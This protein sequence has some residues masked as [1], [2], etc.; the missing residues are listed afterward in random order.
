MFSDEPQRRG[1]AASRRASKLF[2]LPR[3]ITGD[4]GIRWHVHHHHRS[5]RHYAALPDGDARH[6]DGSLANPN[7][8][9]DYYWHNLVIRRRG[10][11]QACDGVR[12]VTWRIKNPHLSGNSAVPANHNFLPDR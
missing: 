1:M 7:V 3:R 12:G 5:S 2:K 11:S 10:T 8:I 4:H 6:D 9:L